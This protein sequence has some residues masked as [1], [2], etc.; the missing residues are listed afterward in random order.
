[1]LLDE[2]RAAL[3]GLTSDHFLSRD[4]LATRDYAAQLFRPHTLRPVD[5]RDEVKADILS[6][7]GDALTVAVIGHG[8][9]VELDVGRLGACFHINV[10]LSGALRSSTGNQQIRTVVGQAVIL[11]P[12]DP[13]R[14]LWEDDAVQL[15]VRIDRTALEEKL[16]RALGHP[17]ETPV[18]F[19]PM[20]DTSS[21]AGAAW[22]RSMLDALNVY[23]TGVPQV[24]DRLIDDFESAL[25]GQLLYTHP[26]SYTEELCG[27]SIR[28]PHRTIRRAVEYIEQHLTEPLRVDEV[29]AAAGVGT[30]ALQSS[31]KEET[32]ETVTGF[33]RNKRLAGVHADLVS[34]AGSVSDIALRW[35]FSHLSRFSAAYRDRYGQLPSAT[36]RTRDYDAA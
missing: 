2:A 24:R 3:G 22:S 13:V 35:G 6:F 20:M 28:I 16:G 33:I 8:V 26:H 32:G 21:G 30:R 5:G 10:A 1:M 19:V 25:I 15:A 34:G 31:F 27:G 4:L 36:L 7:R 23:R 9:D 12:Q 18:R 14:M 17:I 11:N 29:A